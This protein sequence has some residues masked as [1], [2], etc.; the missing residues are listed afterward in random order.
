MTPEEIN[1]RYPQLIK[2]T[3]FVKIAGEEYKKCFNNM[4][5]KDGFI[6]TIIM[7]EQVNSLYFFEQIDQVFTTMN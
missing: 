7:G 4:Q 3:D 5:K 6:T 2:F 1:K